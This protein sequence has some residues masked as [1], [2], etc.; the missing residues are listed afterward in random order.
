MLLDCLLPGGSVAD[1]LAAADHRSI[2][3][4]LISGDPNQ[5]M[6]VDPALP[7]LPKP[8]S[9]RVLLAVLESARR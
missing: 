4:V 8:F 2:P 7:F 9:Q 5:A 1:L 6:A 3:V